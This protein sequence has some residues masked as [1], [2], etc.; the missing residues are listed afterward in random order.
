MSCRNFYNIRGINV[1]N[2]HKNDMTT[3]KQKEIW[4]CVKMWQII[5]LQK[6]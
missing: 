3:R 4:L 1:I 2:E 6:S 5:V